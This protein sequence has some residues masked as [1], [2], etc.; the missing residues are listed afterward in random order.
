MEV[1]T[2]DVIAK[3]HEERS[4]KIHYIVREIG[5][6]RI[7]FGYRIA[8][9]LFD[10]IC[11]AIASILLIVPFVIL[12]ILI[13]CDSK[14][15]VLYQQERVRE[16][17][18]PFVV[19]KFR[20]M[21]VDAEKNGAQW[22]QNGDNR[23]TKVGA[24]LRKFHLDEL[25]QIP[26]NILVGNM[27]IVGPRPERQV[28]YDAFAQYIHGF[29]QRLYAKPGLTGWAQINGGYALKPEEKIVY[30][31]EYIE[32]CSFWMDLKIICKTIPIVFHQEGAR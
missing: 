4:G 8:K 9:R 31:L 23:C 25:P 10:F 6:P 15:P 14:G 30:D 27:S 16:N 5:K 24:V 32:Q 20:S 3:S 21:H 12:A 26:C 17:G 28:F 19:Y 2:V 11:S 1:A 29:D 7:D 13:K 18:V 22:A